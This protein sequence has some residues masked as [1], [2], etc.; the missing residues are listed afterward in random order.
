MA[1]LGRGFP[2]QV[3]RSRPVD[4]TSAR[5]G[6]STQTLGAFVST[7]SGTVTPPSVTG[8][9]AVT[10]GSFVSQASSSRFATAVSSNGR[11][12]VDQLGDPYFISGKSPQNMVS[13]ST[14]TAVESFFSDQRDRGFNSSQMQLVYNFAADAQTSTAPFSSNT[15]LATNSA[16]WGTIDS[17]L[18]LAAT[19]G[20]TI[21]GNVWDNIS[22]GASVTSVSDA[23]CFAY[24]QFL[25]ARYKTRPNLIWSFGNDFI[26]SQWSARNGKYQQILA[27][28]RD[29]GDTHPTTLWLDT[30]TPDANTSWDTLNDLLLCYIYDTAPYDVTLPAYNLTRTGYPKPVYWGEGTYF[31]EHDSQAGSSSNLELRKLPWWTI[32]AGG[33]GHFFGTHQVWQFG[34]WQTEETTAAAIYSHLALIPTIFAGLN[35]WEKLVPDQTHVFQT[36]G[37]GTTGDLDTSTLATAAI[38][39]DGLLAVVYFPTSRSGITFDTSKLSGTATAY[40]VDPTS[41]STSTVSNPAAPT[42]PGTNAGG[43]ADWVLVFQGSNDRTG[44]AARTLGDFTSSASGTVTPPSFTG[45]SART[46]GAFTSSASGT[47]TPSGISGTSATTLGSFVSAASGTIGENGTSAT[48]LGSFTSNASGSI[49]ENGTSATTLGSFTSAASGTFVPAGSGFSATTLGAFTS[50]ASGTFT[51]PNETGTS[52]TTLGSFTSTAS[53]TSTPPLFTGTS[54][55]TLAAFTSTA[56]GTSTPPGSGGIAA[57]TLNP[58]VSTAVGTSAPPVITGTVAVTLGTFQSN[59]IEIDPNIWLLPPVATGV[60]PQIIRGVPPQIIRGVAK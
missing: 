12:L 45:T 30:E 15:T 55:R 20:F 6:T 22:M 13:V 5:S 51:P 49:G 41:G 60:P 44:T 27:G 40:W 25:G 53:G 17:I 59:G 3:R 24:G 7:A 47:F 36:G 14:L 2:V 33:V 32:T 42:H 35:G 29:Q 56:S 57:V 34:S 50:T 9:A 43:D 16:Y 26:T 37:R 1:R 31:G 46:L 39:A 10:L 48:T 23:N 28:I 4:S 38:T 52:A 8:T 21:W 18:D 58:F 19:Y 54:A 11:Y